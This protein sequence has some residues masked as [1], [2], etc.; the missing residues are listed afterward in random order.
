[1]GVP[2]WR[3]CHLSDIPYLL[4]EDVAAGGDNSGP[5]KTLSTLLSG[6]VAAFAYTGDPNV[7]S[8]QHFQNWPIAYPDQSKQAL[9]IDYPE[10][11]SIYVMGGPNGNN[12]GTITSGEGS[13]ATEGLEQALAWEK[14]LERCNFINSIQEEIGV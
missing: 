1:M 6:S 7:A 11:L 2:Q 4:N 13:G 12:P 14:L 10:K 3:V 5:Q 8:G 9:S